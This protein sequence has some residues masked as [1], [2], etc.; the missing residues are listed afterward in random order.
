MS[1]TY[2][3]IDENLVGGKFPK[4]HNTTTGTMSAPIPIKSLIIK[5]LIHIF[6]NKIHKDNPVAA[7]TLAIDIFKVP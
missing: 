5:S 1:I 6:C 7:K 2:G 4:Q 3:M